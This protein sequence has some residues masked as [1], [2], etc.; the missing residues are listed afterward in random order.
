MKKSY[1]L[2]LLAAMFMLVGC[3]F[4]RKVAGR[5]TS[6]DIEAKRVEIARVEAQKARE[7]AVQD[8]IAAAQEQA[9]I[10][11]EMAVKDSVDALASLKDK[12]CMM[13]NLASLK[14]LSSGDLQH[15]YY[16][17]VG[18]FKDASNADRFIK[19]VSKDPEMEPVKVRFRTGMVAVAVCP[20]NKVAQMPAVVDEVRAKSYCPKDAWILVNAQ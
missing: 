12:G 3:D 13:H 14:G 4:F 19:K 17:V 1:I 8:S 18:S 20:R 9:R 2:I 16:L 7:K 10:A 6:E 5:P 15:R 11:A